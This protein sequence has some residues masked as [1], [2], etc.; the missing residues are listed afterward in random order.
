M[1]PEVSQPHQNF[2]PMDHQQQGLYLPFQSPVTTQYV[3]SSTLMNGQSVAMDSGT[4]DSRV[5]ITPGARMGAAPMAL[6]TSGL[7]NEETG[8]G[9]L[10]AAA[11][12]AASNVDS[13]LVGNYDF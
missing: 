11:A 4:L 13:L 10:F 3:I 7:Y 8:F 2:I 5:S 12:A 1:S 6:T 9:D